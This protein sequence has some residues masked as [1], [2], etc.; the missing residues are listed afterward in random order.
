MQLRSFQMRR[1]INTGE[2]AFTLIELA[3]VMVIFGVIVVLTAPAFN[4]FANSGNVTRATHE[5]AGTLESARSYAMANH[6][7]VWVGFFEEDGS[8]ASTS[9]AVSGTGRIILSVA[10]SRD[11]TLIY[12]PNNVRSPAKNID[13]DRLVQVNELVRIEHMHLKTSEPGKGTGDT[14]DTRPSAQANLAQIGDTSPRNPSLTPLQ[15]PL[16]CSSTAAQYTFR[17]VIQFSP[18]GETRVNNTNY[19]LRPV[20]EIGLQPVRGRMLDG[21]NIAAVQITGILGNV[22]V[23]RK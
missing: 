11:G 14:F 2:G 19:D 18:L 4:E 1:R 15:F 13:P 5:I 8:R 7:Y 20:V 12:D 10:A 3:V 23:Y 17:K 16:G 9:P 21:A 22:K 6:T